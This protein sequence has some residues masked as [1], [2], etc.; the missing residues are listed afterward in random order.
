MDRRAFLG[1]LASPL[2]ASCEYRNGEAVFEGALLG[3]DMALGHR[4][5]DG[6][7]PAP[8]EEQR[9]PIAIVGGGVGGLSAAWRLAK[10]GISD[11][12]LF[13]LEEQAGGN[14]R[15]GANA[16]TPYPLGAHYLPLP[17]HESATV[18][19][20][21]ADLGVLIGDPAAA[22]PRY[23]ERYLVHAPQERLYAQGLWQEGLLP[24]IGASQRDA[25]QYRRFETIV[26]AFKAQRGADGRKPFAIP[27]AQASSD[28]GPRTLDAIN[29]RDWLL[30]QGLDSPRLHWYVDYGCRDDYGA[31]AASTSAWAGL[32]YFACR[33]G[34]AQDAD[35]HSVLTWPAGNGWLVSHLLAWLA[36]RAPDVIRT[37]AM[38]TRLRTAGTSA[39]IDVYLA[40]ENRT[41]RYRADHVIWAAP[42]FVLA[43]LWANP[44][45]GFAAA[46]ARIEVSPWLTANLT[47]DSLPADLGPAG[48]AWD[49]V[50]HDSAALG[51]VV[52]THQTISVRPGP[53][54]LT[55]YWPLT[56]ES[57]AA[58]RARLDTTGW[59]VWADQ[60][61]GE[62]A[63]PHPGLRQQLRRLDLWRWPHAMPRP[64]PGFLSLPIRAMLADLRG[65]LHFA[66]ADLSG[67]SLFE[68]A[69]HAGVVAAQRVAR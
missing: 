13:E 6:K 64:T 3:P 46:A 60:I 61:L 17:T 49:N 28:A 24:R 15:S 52:A 33:D 45:P 53:T 14:A 68:E 55:W 47:L 21:L 2:I 63:K 58:A 20:L 39:D 54:V 18:R 4:L 22:V 48:L 8:T 37:R 59:N 51:Y 29:M 12:K 65:P 25:D 50:L 16:A 1:A 5:R 40:R 10:R 30:Q 66:H 41:V 35:P 38:C 36:S 11:F 31:R 9:I 19:E 7:L 32:H 34:A 23:D 62:L 42:A 67:M 57:P 44:P 56:D 69:N 26:D 27:S 43:R